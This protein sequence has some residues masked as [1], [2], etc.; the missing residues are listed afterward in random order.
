MYGK[1]LVVVYVDF[2]VRVDVLISVIVAKLVVVRVW[3][4]VMVVGLTFVVCKSSQ[5]HVSSKF[6]KSL[7]DGTTG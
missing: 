1:E 7:L 3:S 4:T 5:Q 6:C 2:S